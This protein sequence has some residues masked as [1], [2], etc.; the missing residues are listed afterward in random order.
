MTNAEKL[1]D[2]DTLANLIVD[3]ARNSCTCAFKS[4]GIC[5]FCYDKKRVKEWLESEVEE[6]GRN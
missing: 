2:T 3:V 1:T 4:Y 6:D 5:E